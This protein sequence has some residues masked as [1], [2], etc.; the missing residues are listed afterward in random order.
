MKELPNPTSQMLDNDPYFDAI[1]DVIKSWDINIPDYYTGY[2]GGN[3]SH[4]TLIYEAIAKVRRK[5]PF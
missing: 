4:V 1:W 5:F 2:C 3:G